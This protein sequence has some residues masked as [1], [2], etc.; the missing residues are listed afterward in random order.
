MKQYKAYGILLASALIANACSLQAKNKKD[1]F[2]ATKEKAKKH[3]DAKVQK[4]AALESHGAIQAWAT[5]AEQ[6]ITGVDAQ[7][8]LISADQ[9][10]NLAVQ[11][12]ALA[13]KALAKINASKN[14]DHEKAQFIQAVK[15]FYTDVINETQQEL[16]KADPAKDKDHIAVLKQD[17]VRFQNGLKAFEQ[18][19]LKAIFFDP[20]KYQ[21]A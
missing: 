10:K 3:S 8:N 5:Q 12:D 9:I 7:G 14:K 18:E 16:A 20:S 15:E 6:V 13:L 1:A 4:L 21:A 19:G 17:V 2:K 11:A